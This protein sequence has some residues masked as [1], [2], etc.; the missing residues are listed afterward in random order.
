MAG[1]GARRDSEI[2][3]V[4]APVD[5]A[6]EAADQPGELAALG[7]RPAGQQ[8]GEPAVPGEQEFPDR[9]AVFYSALCWPP[10]P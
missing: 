5:V 7:G 10:T 8:P 2:Q 1:F 3:F 4:Q 6:G 9:R